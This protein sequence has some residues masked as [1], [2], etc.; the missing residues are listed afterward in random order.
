MGEK[1]DRIWED[2]I[3]AYHR[4]IAKDRADDEG[5]VVN[6]D[7]ITN[8]PGEGDVTYTSDYD[9]TLIPYGTMEMNTITMRLII[10]STILIESTHKY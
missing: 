10:I 6:P 8:K 9:Q 3:S 7:G 1:W 2:I 4:K 5:I